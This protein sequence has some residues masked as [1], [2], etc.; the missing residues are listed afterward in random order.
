MDSDSIVQNEF[1]NNESL[2]EFYTPEHISK[3]LR[4]VT[5][6]ALGDEFEKE[7]VIWDCCCGRFALTKELQT[8]DYSNVY[9]STL[10]AIDIRKSKAEKGNKFAYDF[11]NDDCE[12]LIDTS[13]FMFGEY[14][15]PE[16]LLAEFK[17]P[18]GRPILFYINPPYASHSIA[19]VNTETRGK[20]FSTNIIQDS[21]GRLGVAR[22]QLLAQFLYRILMMKRIYENKKIYISIIMPDKYLSLR[23]YRDFRAEFLSEFKLVAGN[24]FPSTEFK[25]LSNEFCI[26]NLVFAPNESGEVANEF[27]LKHYKTVDNE[28][29][30]IYDKLVYNYDYSDIDCNIKLR[31]LGNYD[32]KISPLVMTSGCNIMSNSINA[33]VADGF[34]G[35]VFNYGTNIGS[36]V[37][38]LGAMRFPFTQGSNISITKGNIRDLLVQYAIRSLALALLRGCDYNNDE[39]LFPDVSS[40]AYQ[41]LK[42]NAILVSL[43]SNNSHFVGCEFNGHRYYN[44]MIHSKEVYNKLMIEKVSSDNTSEI[45]KTL[46]SIDWFVSDELNK[47]LATGS[48]PKSGLDFYNSLYDDFKLAYK[49]KNDFYKSHP[50]YQTNLFDLGW[51]QVKFIMKELYPEQYK[52]NRRLFREYIKDLLDLV[53]E[54]GFLRRLQ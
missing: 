12:K 41:T 42:D 51:Y 36:C 6:S 52:E 30:Y 28:F 17:N 54:A 44:T 22:G 24:R 38:K 25:G 34:L 47:D 32:D 46:D 20:D 14:K 7:F 4:E 13:E 37:A 39:F 50:E 27:I 33:K 40:K 21:M 49:S 11:L 29:K 16:C 3:N 45:E 8:D 2:G 5:A 53:Y 19:G 1:K 10:R 23:S 43:F 18:N 48:I 35:C 15:M 9:C 26:G 31:G